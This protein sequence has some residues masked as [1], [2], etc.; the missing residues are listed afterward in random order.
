MY[1]IEGNGDDT[2][3][4]CPK[5]SMTLLAILVQVF[6]SQLNAEALTLFRMHTC[7]HSQPLPTLR[8][9]EDQKIEQLLT[10]L[11]LTTGNLYGSASC[12]WHCCAHHQPHSEQTHGA[13]CCRREAHRQGVAEGVSKT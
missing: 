2:V 1:S 9:P 8:G 13:V 11:M 7:F 4:L 5:A 3:F 10:G 12:R 6:V